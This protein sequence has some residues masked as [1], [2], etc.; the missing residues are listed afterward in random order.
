MSK[1]RHARCAAA[2]LLVA[3]T[4]CSFTESDE[5][6]RPN[7]TA[8]PTSGP[9]A[10]S[11]TAPSGAKALKALGDGE[12][13]T[14]G[15]GPTA[16]NVNGLLLHLASAATA[17]DLPTT[18]GR[19]EL[20]GRVIVAQRDTADGLRSLGRLPTAVTADVPLVA[21]PTPADAKLSAQPA[22]LG[23]GGGADSVAEVTAAPAKQVRTGSMVIPADGPVRL[24]VTDTPKCCGF[25]LVRHN[26]AYSVEVTTTADGPDTL[27]LIAVSGKDPVA[28]VKEGEKFIPPAATAVPIGELAI[29]SMTFPPGL[30][31]NGQS[32]VT[33]PPPN[34]EKRASVKLPPP[35]PPGSWCG[36]LA[37]RSVPFGE[38]VAIWNQLGRPG[39]MDADGNG[40]PCETRY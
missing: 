30:V 35:V 5:I 38:T 11:T 27:H 31:T 3:F 15:T 23:D 12:Q 39:H 22:S 8:L 29:P 17:A 6:S 33:N 32:A 9:A 14:R 4:G 36:Y 10:S 7:E 21:E 24:V 26:G 1:L 37:L 2:I 19:Y 34:P 28:E 16:K 25:A 13:P 40:I 18:D 20:T